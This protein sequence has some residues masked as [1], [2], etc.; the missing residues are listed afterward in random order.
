VLTFANG[1]SSCLPCQNSVQCTD[2]LTQLKALSS[3]YTPYTTCDDIDSL[4]TTV[5]TPV[6]ATVIATPTVALTSTDDTT[7]LS[8]SSTV[9]PKTT[10]KNVSIKIATINGKSTITESGTPLSELT[11]GIDTTLKILTSD[12]TLLNY[13]F[14]FSSTSPE[15]I[16]T[17][18]VDNIINIGKPGTSS[19]YISI[20]T[21][22]QN[23]E[24]Y[25]TSSSNR[26]LFF[27]IKIIK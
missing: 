18:I 17:P 16:I 15:K 23:K 13:S 14:A 9:R 22:K 11:V 21:G 5:A 7:A 26:S 27:K 20:Q 19:S 12:P 10:V 6:I 25:L 8:L 2:R 1:S 3:T 24:I 4:S